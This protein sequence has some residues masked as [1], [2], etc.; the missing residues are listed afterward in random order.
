MELCE[1]WPP[2]WDEYLRAA[3][4][5]QRTAPDPCLPTRGTPFGI[6]F[7]RD[8]RTNLDAFTPA[9]D[10]DRFGTGLDNFVAEEY[11]TCLELRGIYKHIRQ[12]DACYNRE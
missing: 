12:E 7:G 10:G 5:I 9:L 3:C 2:R 6:L 4:W 11:Q 1:F 8:A